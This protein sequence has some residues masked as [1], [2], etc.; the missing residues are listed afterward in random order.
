[1]CCR[2]DLA[3]LHSASVVPDV[4]NNI[5]QSAG[6]QLNITYASVGNQPAVNFHTSTGRLTLAQTADRPYV[7]V[8]TCLL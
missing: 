3:D 4:L 8:R 6:V 7:H 1:M 2:E 5:D